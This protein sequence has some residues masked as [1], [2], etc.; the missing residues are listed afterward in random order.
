MVLKR[1]FACTTL[2]WSYDDGDPGRHSVGTYDLGHGR[3]WAL[4]GRLL[5]QCWPFL[6]TRT[7]ILKP[8]V[9]ADRCYGYRRVHS[10][11]RNSGCSSWCRWMVG[12]QTITKQTD[13]PSSRS[14]AMVSRHLMSSSRQL[15]IHGSSWKL[16]TRASA[17]AFVLS[18]RWPR[19]APYTWV[20]W[21]IP[22]LPDYAHGNYSQNFSWASVPIDPMNVP[23]KF[24]VRSF[25]RSWDN[26][27][28]TQK[29]GSPWIRPRSLISKFF[30]SFYSDWP[31]KCTRQIW[32]P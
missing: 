9:L 1:C 2:I 16:T 31:C 22:G 7:Y 6:H 15:S 23:T 5:T 4:Y 8:V 32:S 21:K 11:R 25:T 28:G 27:G 10:N 3:S 17:A 26:I 14:A 24:E 29:I 12:T 20:P 13:R 18:P 30:R 19:N